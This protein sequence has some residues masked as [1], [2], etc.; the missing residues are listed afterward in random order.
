MDSNKVKNERA[1]DS[2]P[3]TGPEDLTAL[4]ANAMN[5]VGSNDVLRD[6]LAD[7][8]TQADQM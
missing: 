6:I 4:L 7:A 5:M 1:S 8:I 3:S 2:T